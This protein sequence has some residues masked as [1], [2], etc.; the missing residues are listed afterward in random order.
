MGG[1]AGTG[2]WEK[3]SDEE[4][5]ENGRSGS[6]SSGTVRSLFFPLFTF[7][8]SSVSQL[9]QTLLRHE[10]RGRLWLVPAPRL[11]EAESTS[12]QIPPRDMANKGDRCLTGLLSPTNTNTNTTPSHA[13][14]V[15]LRIRSAAYPATTYAP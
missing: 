5:F 8:S 9:P 3:A 4:S 12:C 14:T 1:S 2:R 6:G 13:Y 10:A 11:A 7:P 15:G